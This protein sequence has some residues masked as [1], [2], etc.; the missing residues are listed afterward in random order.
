[1]SAV[2]LTALS[3]W[4][5]I[6]EASGLP[7]P[8]TH[9]MQM[10]PS[11][12]QT[13]MAHL[14]G[15]EADPSGVEA[16]AGE[17]AAIA[18]DLGTP[19]FLRTDQTSGKHDWERT[20]FV[21][22][23]SKLAGHLYAIAEYS[24][25]A[26][27]PGL[28]WNT[29]VVREML[30]TVPVA[31]CPRYGNMPVC[32]EFRFFVD[33]GTVE[34]FHPYWPRYALERGGCDLSDAEYAVLCDPGDIDTLRELA[35][36]TGRAVGGRW[37][38]DLLETKRGWFVTDMAEA[39]KSFHWDGCPA[40]VDERAKRQDPEEGLGPKDASAVGATSAETP[41]P[42]SETTQGSNEG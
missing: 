39:D 37:S 36:L 30:P 38:V 35:A 3:Y 40:S 42:N 24:E 15:E 21:S 6:V 27:F 29:W 41:D 12:Q 19:L 20:C 17:L 23:L 18:A 5:P 26:G 13:I 11:V 28:P 31:L 9:I 2:D 22:D 7:V 25:C 8:R 34:C 10:P 14:W 32:K 16:F 4:F 1:M 33:G